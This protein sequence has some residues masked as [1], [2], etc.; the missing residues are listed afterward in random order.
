MIPKTIHYCWFGKGQKNEL[1]QRCITSWKIFLPDYRI[2]EWNEDNFNV[3]TTIWTKQAYEAKKWAFVSD[4][5]RLYALFSE[6]GL[7]FDAD[8]EVLKSLDP[9]MDCKLLLGFES[10]DMITTAVIGAERGNATIEKMLSV[11]RQKTFLLADGS[12]DTLPNPYVLSEYVQ[13]LGIQFTGKEQS[14]SMYHIYPTI[15]FSPNNLTRIWEKPSSKSFT[16]HHFD[17]SWIINKK[18]TKSLAGRIRRYCVGIL[19][20]LLGT[21][22][23]YDLKVS[24]QNMLKKTA[25]RADI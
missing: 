13:E 24:V 6:G 19:R 20:N 21:E 7:Y 23:A 1:I 3:D 18:N 10:N 16:I 8:V 22:R 11:Y 25:R 15:V 4:Y 14:C 2:V 9:L 17:Q 5:V 12:F